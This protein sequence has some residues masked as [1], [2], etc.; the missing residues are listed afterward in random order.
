MEG[1]PRG[2]HRD[3]TTSGPSGESAHVCGN[4]WR[5]WT[6]GARTGCSESLG[7]S[8]GGRW[9]GVA[10]GAQIHVLPGD[11]TLRGWGCRLKVCRDTDNTLFSPDAQVKHQVE[12]EAFSQLLHEQWQHLK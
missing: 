1:G 3:E 5:V 8:R 9:A 11:C 4:A 12:E 7:E 6:E 10:S 2:L